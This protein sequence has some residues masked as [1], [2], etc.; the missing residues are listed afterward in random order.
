MSLKKFITDHVIPASQLTEILHR[1]PVAA[2]TQDFRRWQVEAVQDTLNLVVLWSTRAKASE[3]KK[4][5][6]PLD[7]LTQMLL[8]ALRPPVP[9]STKLPHLRLS[10]GKDALLTTMSTDAQVFAT[11]IL[12][13]SDVPAL[14]LSLRH[15]LPELKAGFLS[16]LSELHKVIDYSP[17]RRG[18]WLD[19]R[20][21]AGQLWS[22]K[23]SRW[24]TLAR[25]SSWTRS[26]ELL[27][28]KG[29]THARLRLEDVF[30]S[31]PGQMKLDVSWAKLAELSQPAPAPVPAT[32]AEPAPS[33]VAAPSKS[34]ASKRG[35]VAAPEPLPAGVR[36]VTSDAGVATV[37][38]E[39]D[40]LKGSGSKALKKL[41]SEFG[42]KPPAEV[43]DLLACRKHEEAVSWQAVA[44]AVQRA[45]AWR[46]S[47]LKSFGQLESK[48]LKLVQNVRRA[49]LFARFEATFNQEERAALADVFGAKVVAEKKPKPAS[50][51]RAVVHKRSGAALATGKLPK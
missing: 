51:T 37:V 12:P 5:V 33:K 43:V 25:N 16:A 19:A 46:E 22:N 4:A 42:E 27:G 13:V 44:S 1:A 10:T 26:I 3:L 6:K 35:P 49:N 48:L 23:P 50:R 34:P 15:V 41:L 29:V 45:V 14:R 18:A 31:H 21:L 11:L 28:L 17:S 8:S 32:P 30:G 36:L 2:D 7:A 20:R 40:P 38:A 24:R 39:V 47:Q 9:A